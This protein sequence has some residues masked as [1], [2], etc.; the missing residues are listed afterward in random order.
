MVKMKG[1]TR[2]HS[3]DMRKYE[4]IF[5]RDRGANEHFFYLDFVSPFS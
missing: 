5:P 3:K 2:K 4:K 1:V